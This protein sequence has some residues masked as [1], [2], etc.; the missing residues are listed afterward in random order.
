MVFHLLQ[1]KQILTYHRFDFISFRKNKKNRSVFFNEDAYFIEW[2]KNGTT[3][4]WA[5][6]EWESMKH[7]NYSFDFV[8]EN[9]I[10]KRERETNN[11]LKY[12]EIN[13]SPLKTPTFQHWLMC[14]SH[15]KWYFRGESFFSPF[16]INSSNAFHLHFP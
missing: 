2:Y 12:L 6:W 7:S 13:P 1:S 14:W 8:F 5:A 11:W 10:G 15:S 4:Q 3:F 9:G 16:K